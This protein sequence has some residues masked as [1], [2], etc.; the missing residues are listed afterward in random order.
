MDHLS[1]LGHDPAVKLALTVLKAE[2]FTI[3]S[4]TIGRP[5]KRKASKQIYRPQNL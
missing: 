4:C 2:K 1:S 5:Q 3:S